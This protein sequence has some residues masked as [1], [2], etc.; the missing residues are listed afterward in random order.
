VKR[1]GLLALSILLALPALAAPRHAPHPAPAA[2][3]SNPYVV[4]P[5]SPYYVPGAGAYGAGPIVG[6]VG[7]PEDAVAPD[8][9]ASLDERD[10]ALRETALSYLLGNLMGAPNA[11]GAGRAVHQEPAL[12]FSIGHQQ[13]EAWILQNVRSRGAR[14][15]KAVLSL[16][17]EG[18]VAAWAATYRTEARKLLAAADR[19][20]DER[21]PDACQA[22]AETVRASRIPHA[23]RPAL[24]ADTAAALTW[25]ARAAESCAQGLRDT[26]SLR[27]VHAREAFAAVDGDCSRTRTGATGA[28][29]AAAAE[30][31]SWPHGVQAV[32]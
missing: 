3:L 6:D 4:R 22:L 11:A 9:L 15:A 16:G 26:T 7:S 23:P 12:D 14:P 20:G 18:A 8:E 2:R 10:R 29:R 28:A 24:E 5:S 30:T 31:S 19:A 32:R 13:L 17:D 21:S 1:A 25:L 27:L